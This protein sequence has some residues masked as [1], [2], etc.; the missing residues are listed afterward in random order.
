M[1]KN[2]QDQYLWKNVPIPSRLWGEEVAKERQLLILWEI[3]HRINQSKMT[4]G[5]YTVNNNY[6]VVSKHNYIKGNDT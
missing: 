2:V 4:S 6:Y 3:N 5:Q 1:R